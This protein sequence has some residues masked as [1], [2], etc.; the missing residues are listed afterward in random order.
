VMAM[1]VNPAIEGSLASSWGHRDPAAM[2]RPRSTVPIRARGHVVPH[3]EAAHMTATAR[4]YLTQKKPL[5]AGGHPHMTIERD[6]GHPTGPL[7]VRRE[8]GEE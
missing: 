7:V 6:I 2:I 8:T 4:P 3:S 1:S 5:P